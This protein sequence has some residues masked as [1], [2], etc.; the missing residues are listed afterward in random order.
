MLHVCQQSQALGFFLNTCLRISGP[1]SIS[2]LFCSFHQD[3]PRLPE[4]RNASSDSHYDAPINRQPAS[5]RLAGGVGGASTQCPG[6]KL[7]AG[8]VCVFSLCL[9][10]AADQLQDYIPNVTLVTNS[11]FRLRVRETRLQA[12]RSDVTQVQEDLKPG[13]VAFHAVVTVSGSDWKLFLKLESDPANP[14]HQTLTRHA[15]NQQSYLLRDPGSRA[16][17]ATT[18]EA[19]GACLC[20]RQGSGAG[21]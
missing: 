15:Q 6:P 20:L 3:P 17:A 19:P 14:N 21:C 12:S 13:F 1:P 16:M 4:L 5:Q 11:G 10:R 9:A 7:N 18:S 2:F 8:N